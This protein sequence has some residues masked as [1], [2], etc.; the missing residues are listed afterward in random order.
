MNKIKGNNQHPFLRDDRFEFVEDKKLVE[1]LQ[2]RFKEIF[3]Y[4]NFD[5][6]VKFLPPD[7]HSESFAYKLI[8]IVHNRKDEIHNA[9]QLIEEMQ[10]KIPPLMQRLDQICTDIEKYLSK[11]ER[12][13][14]QSI[15][16][17]YKNG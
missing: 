5:D 16:N 7:R 6:Y 3:T 10:F 4:D 2:K 12:N 13:N 1:R 17:G 11:D 8:E 14:L 9:H 15:K